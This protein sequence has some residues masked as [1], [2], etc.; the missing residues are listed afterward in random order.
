MLAVTG[1]AQAGL[2]DFV[3]IKGTN[4]RMRLGD[5]SHLVFH[6]NPVPPGTNSFTGAETSALADEI[7]MDLGPGAL[8]GRV[9]ILLAKVTEGPAASLPGP[10]TSCALITLVDRNNLGTGNP[11]QDQ[12]LGMYTETTNALA[13][14]YI[15]DDPSPGGFN[16]LS[17]PSTTPVTGVIPFAAKAT[18]GTFTWDSANRG[19]GQ[20]W[21]NL[22]RNDRAYYDWTTEAGYAPNGSGV[23]SDYF[24]FLSYKNGA[25][26]IIHTMGFDTTTGA[27]TSYIL[28]K[29]IPLPGPAAMG[30]A[31]LLGLG[32]IRRRSAR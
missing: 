2:N 10:V 18:T 8:E 6:N 4:H 26:T 21:T 29:L 28:D 24:Q 1:A 32:V 31:G 15:N 27:H 12:R 22:E 25:W 5:M 11:T 20:A 7:E 14:A 9:T 23:L 19:D 30:L 16:D 17:D 13:N 3:Q